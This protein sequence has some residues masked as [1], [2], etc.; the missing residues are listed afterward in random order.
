MTTRRAK[1]SAAAHR[2]LAESAGGPR[3][4]IFRQEGEYWTIVYEG[5]LFRLRDGK[6]LQY[7]AYLLRHPDERIHC[8]DLWSTTGKRPTEAVS[9]ERTRVAVTK[10]IKASVT[11]IATLHPALAHHLSGRIKTGYFC[12]YVCDSGEGLPWTF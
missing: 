3:G 7:L 2:L 8:G 9:A 10:R 6:G 1:R 5:T 11:K 4:H 12:V